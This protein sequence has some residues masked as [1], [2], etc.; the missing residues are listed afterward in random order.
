MTFRK[1]R[2]A[3]STDQMVKGDGADERDYQG[4]DGVLW[5]MAESWLRPCTTC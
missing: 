2:G 3:L 4:P 1:K 5:M